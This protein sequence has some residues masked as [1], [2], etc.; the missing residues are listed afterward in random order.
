MG[1]VPA[2][3]VKNGRLSRINHFTVFFELLTW[4]SLGKFVNTTTTTTKEIY[5]KIKKSDRLNKQNK[6]SDCEAHITFCHHRTTDAVKLDLNGNAIS[7][8][9]FLNRRFINRR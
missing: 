8:F 4:T 1:T 6:N 2:N 9:K 5:I 3:V 7:R